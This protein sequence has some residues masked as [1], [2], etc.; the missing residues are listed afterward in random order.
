M[1]F[2]EQLDIKLSVLV[3]GIIGGIISLTYEE[4]ISTIRALVMIFVGGATAAYL[5]PSLQY[6]FSLDPKFSNGIGFVLGLISMKLTHLLLSIAEKVRKEPIVILQIFNSLKNASIQSST[7]TSIP[8]V[9]SSS[10]AGEATEESKIEQDK[11]K[12][13]KTVTGFDV[14]TLI[15]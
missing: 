1:N 14:I 8:V 10:T 15:Y 7:R 11:E 3:S 13:A 2:E 5:Q 6:F 4:K 9:D 12:S